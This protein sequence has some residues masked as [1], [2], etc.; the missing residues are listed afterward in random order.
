[1]TIAE[2][3]KYLKRMRERYWAA[4]RVGRGKLLAEMEAVKGLYRKSLVRP[5]CVQR[6]G[7]LV[8]G[9]TLERIPRDR[10]RGRAYGPDGDD[11]IRV[12]GESLD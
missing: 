9:P 8:P 2:R 4:A 11:T 7:R 3:R 1:M 6:T 5:V 10:S 12:V